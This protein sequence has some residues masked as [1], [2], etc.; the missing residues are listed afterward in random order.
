MDSMQPVRSPLPTNAAKA[1]PDARPMRMALFAGGVAALSALVAAIIS[2]PGP[3]A[4]R[5]V[6]PQQSSARQDPAVGATVSPTDIR[7]V[8]PIQYVQLSPGQTAPPGATVIDA[9]A[10][11]P[12]TVVV[13]VPAPAQGV[14]GGG[15]AAAAPTAVIIKTTQSGKVVP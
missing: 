6:A 13:N 5:P 9:S 12:I 4:T 7:V 3:A 11:T 15:G 8:R 1:K 2:P 14:S 10:P